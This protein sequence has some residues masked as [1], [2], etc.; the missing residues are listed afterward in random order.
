MSLLSVAAALGRWLLLKR[1]GPLR[2]GLPSAEDARRLML[3]NPNHRT[4]GELLE[5]R[6]FKE[7]AAEMLRN[8]AHWVRPAGDARAADSIS[9]FRPLS[10][11]G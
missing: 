11:A 7:A 3:E 6:E 1:S 4:D 9:R 2:V 8:P 10:S 5:I